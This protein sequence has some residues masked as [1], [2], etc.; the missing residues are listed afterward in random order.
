MKFILKKYLLSTAAVFILLQIVPA[1]SIAGSWQNLFFASF[2]LSIVT[3]ILR[4]IVNLL[5]L[6][7]NLVTLNLSSWFVYLAT[8]YVWTAMLPQIRISNW[9]ISGLQVGTITV[10]AFNLVKWQVTVVSAF[11]FIIV[12][13]IL[14]WIFK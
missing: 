7:I 3:F 14:N 2:V 12:Y 8:F 11:V 9:Y 13:K 6:P 10:S 1:V 4:P 5:L